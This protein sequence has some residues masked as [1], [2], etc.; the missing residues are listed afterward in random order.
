MDRVDNLRQIHDAII[1]DLTERYRDRVYTIM[2]YDMW[3]DDDGQDPQPIITPAIILELDAIDPGDDDGTDR[4]SLMLTW[5]AHCII[6]IRTQ[7]MQIELREFA[8][9]VLSHVRHNRWGLGSAVS[10]P[11][12]LV[13]IPDEFIPENAGYE[14]WIAQW[15][16]QSY[17]GSDFWAG[18]APKEVYLG[19]APRIGADYVDDYRRVDT[20]PEPIDLI[21]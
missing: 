4:Q 8:A 19:I 16:Q 12:D 3:P 5:S 9:D 6:S 20:D 7:D 17:V 11:E 1:D 2:S 21:R 13:A 18:V 10:P 15:R 14:S